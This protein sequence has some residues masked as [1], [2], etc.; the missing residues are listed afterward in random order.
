MF[1][2]EKQG[3]CPNR[4]I[5]EYLLSEV[6]ENL[7]WYELNAEEMGREEKRLVS[8]TVMPRLDRGGYGIVRLMGYPGWTMEGA[9]NHLREFEV[10]LEALK[11]G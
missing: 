7:W 2:G 1:W 4:E 10:D 6:R 5:C 11:C 8:L 9:V 3:Q